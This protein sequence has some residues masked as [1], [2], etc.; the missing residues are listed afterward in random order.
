MPSII[1]QSVLVVEVNLRNEVNTTR[2]NSKWVC[3]SLFC[4]FT[5]RIRRFSC[6]GFRRREVPGG[7]HLCLCNKTENIGFS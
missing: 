3:I 5:C 2:Q 6:V 1:L 4:R 7:T